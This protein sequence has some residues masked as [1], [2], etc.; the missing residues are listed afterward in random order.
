MTS[1]CLVVSSLVYVERLQ[2]RGSLT[3]LSPHPRHHRTYNLNL[4]E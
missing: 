3:V 1:V 2:A 4:Q